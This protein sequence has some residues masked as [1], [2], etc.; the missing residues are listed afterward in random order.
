[1]IGFSSVVCVVLIKR[2]GNLSVL[3]PVYESLILQEK[4]ERMNVLQRT[5]AQNMRILFR[6]S[7]V[8]SCM[9]AAPL[10]ND[11]LRPKKHL[12]TLR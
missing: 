7:V 12:H 3:R 6:Q 2:S 1:M 10:S 11:L 4:T 5:L 8:L 9:H